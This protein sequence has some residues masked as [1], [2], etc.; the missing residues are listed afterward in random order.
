METCTVLFPDESCFMFCRADERSSMCRCHNERYAAKYVLKHFLTVVVVSWCRTVLLR[1]MPSSTG[2]RYCSIIL[3][4]SL[5]SLMVSFNITLPDHTLH[6]SA[7]IFYSKTTFSSLVTWL[8]EDRQISPQEN[9]SG[10]SWIAYFVRGTL[11][12]KHNRNCSWLYRLND[13]TS[14]NAPFK[15]FLPACAVIVHLWLK[16]EDIPGTEHFDWFKLWWHTSA[17]THQVQM[18]SSTVR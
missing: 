14:P 18:G 16:H 9:T 8:E 17:L 13:K 11:R 15:I 5:T 10:T 7:E 6:E 12:H 2:M 1:S 4:H 3:F